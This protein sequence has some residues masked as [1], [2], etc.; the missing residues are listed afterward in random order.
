MGPY[1]ISGPLGFYL[2]EIEKHKSL[3]MNQLID[4]TPYHKSHATRIVAKLTEMGLVD[5][6]V[7]PEDM[8]GYILTITKQGIEIAQKVFSAHQDWETLVDS[9]LSKEESNILESLMEKT[10]LHL[11]KHFGEDCK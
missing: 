1:G 2:V 10:Y 6:S 3:K 11:K 5:K 4:L 7:D 8:R 9:A